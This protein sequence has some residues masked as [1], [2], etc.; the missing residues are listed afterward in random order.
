MLQQAWGS[1]VKPEWGMQALSA[2]SEQKTCRIDGSAAD[3]DERLLLGRLRYGQVLELYVV[4]LALDL[5]SHHDRFV[6]S[7][8]SF[9]RAQL[10]ALTGWRARD[11]SN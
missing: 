9:A 1:A 7:H 11:Q 10:A 6:A 2:A 3:P 5:L 8:A 4:D